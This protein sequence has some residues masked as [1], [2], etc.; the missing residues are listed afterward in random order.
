MSARLDAFL[1]WVAGYMRLTH[2]VLDGPVG[3]HHGAIR[4]LTLGFPPEMPP[5]LFKSDL[6]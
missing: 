6:D 2:G 1:K 5:P 4:P 3:N